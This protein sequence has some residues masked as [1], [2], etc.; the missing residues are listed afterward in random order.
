MLVVEELSICAKG[1]KWWTANDVGER[2][3]R[4]E[5][6]EHEGKKEDYQLSTHTF[7]VACA[8]FGVEKMYCCCT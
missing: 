2:G 4:S 5:S 8:S 6:R 1:Y 3:M 7:M